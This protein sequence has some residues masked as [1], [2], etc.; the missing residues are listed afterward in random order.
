MTLKSIREEFARGPHLAL[1]A[2]M[3]CLL[4]VAGCGSKEES[5]G[6]DTSSGSEAPAASA[7]VV[8]PATAGTIM[9]HV[10]LNG[11][12]PT[13]MAI[14]LSSEQTCAH[15]AET[16]PVMTENV[17]VNDNGTLKNVF[18]YVKSGLE[19]MNF[20]APSTPVVLDQVGCQYVP[21]VIGLQVKQPLLIKNSDEGVLHNIHATSEV[22]NRF[23]F[24]MPKVM[25]T[26]KEFKK[27][28]VMVKVKCDV[29]GWMNSYIGVMDHPYFAV[30]GDDG[31]FEFPAL[32]P[33][34]YVIETWHEQYGT[35]TQNVTVAAKESKD[36][37]FTYDAAGGSH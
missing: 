20:P 21:H 17:V 1:A 27:P 3:T 8:D 10:A 26:T 13:M 16:N 19:N 33:G 24:G 9:G 36:L 28:E 34:D 29:H 12:A 35:Q 7:T 14:D 6:G 37:T 22:G 2:G 11:N 18:V 15:H 32:P 25:E 4:L 23:N 30:T 5:S 31:S